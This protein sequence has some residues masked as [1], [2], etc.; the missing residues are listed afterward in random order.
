MRKIIFS[1]NNTL[2]GCADHTK[3]IADDELHEFYTD[4]LSDVDVILMGRKTY[5]LMEGF[6]PI[7]YEDRRSTKSMIGF[8]NIFNPMHKIVFSNTLK[9]VNWQNSQLEN[10][11][12]QEVISDLKD[13]GGK[14]ISAGS[15]SI[16]IQLL[17]LN[18]IDEFW[19]VVQPI[20]GGNGNKLFEDFNDTRKLKFIDLKK[21]NSGVVG[22]HYQKMDE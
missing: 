8:A 11:S 3:V 7:V 13:Q 14:N 9:E 15:L 12:L 17:K 18:L 21:F 16:A 10:R 19:F 4:L 2:D 5:L 20:I 1:I 22:L 6:W